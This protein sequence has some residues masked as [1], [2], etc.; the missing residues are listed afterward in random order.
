MFD[1]EP[2]AGTGTAAGKIGY[3]ALQQLPG[4]E[5]DNL[6]VLPVGYRGQR[7]TDRQF[8][9]EITAHGIKGD[10]HDAP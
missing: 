10:T 6:E 8:R 1:T 7:A 9:A 4:T 3:L 2:P 5:E